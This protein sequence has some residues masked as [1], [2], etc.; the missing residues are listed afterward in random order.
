MIFRS[1]CQQGINWDGTNPLQD[2]SRWKKWKED[3]VELNNVKIF[4]CLRPDRKRIGTQLREFADA[5][6]Y[7]R[8]S[9]CYLR[10]EGVNGT[11]ESRIVCARSRLCGSW[12][13]TIP[14]LE[15][16]AALDAVKLEARTGAS[17]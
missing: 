17:R 10:S 13:N 5:S 16:E 9:V 3:L 11:F 6:S 2:A 1:V 8:G 14:R 12:V 7:A 4:R 15:L